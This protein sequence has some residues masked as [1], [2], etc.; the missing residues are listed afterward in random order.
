MAPDPVAR[1]C[2]L[3]AKAKRVN[4]KPPKGFK[5]G[6]DVFGPQ[7]AELQ[8]RVALAVALREANAGV[9][10]VPSG[11]NRG[12]RVEQYQAVDNIPGGG[13]AWCAAFVTWCYRQ[14]FW[15]EDGWNVAYVPSWVAEARAGRHGLSLVSNPG[16]GDLVAFDWQGDGKHDHIGIVRWTVPVPGGRVAFTVEGNTSAG[17]SGSQ[18][19][20]D[21]VYKRNR[22]CRTGREV[23]IRVSS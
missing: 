9:H 21:G 8:R 22:F 19:N 13:Y 12:P 3:A 1:K 17:A 16:A 23:F 14:A 18:D 10:E 4:V 7:A 20:G 6:T 11:S 5:P 2:R 15:P